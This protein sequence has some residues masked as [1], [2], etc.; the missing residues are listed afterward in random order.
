VPIPE[1]QLDIPFDSTRDATVEIF[2]K[3]SLGFVINNWA[4]KLISE[5]AWATIVLRLFGFA[6]IPMMFYVKH[7][8]TSNAQFLE[9]H[10]DRES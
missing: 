4:R 8:S 5:K 6:K 9:A 2:T 3:V 1:L 7:Y 10:E